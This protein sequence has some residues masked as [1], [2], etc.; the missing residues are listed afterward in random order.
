MLAA[1]VGTCFL[2]TTGLVADTV[3]LNYYMEFEFLR[4]NMMNMPMNTPPVTMMWIQQ[5]VN[6]P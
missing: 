2:D 1:Q 6:M 3:L 4:V 5:A